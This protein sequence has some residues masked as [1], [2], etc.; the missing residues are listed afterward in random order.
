[1]R[2]VV[3]KFNGRQTTLLFR[4]PALGQRDVVPALSGR[5][6]VDV[7]GRL[8][9]EDDGLPTR[10]HNT[11]LPLRGTGWR[12]LKAQLNIAGTH[13]LQLDLERFRCRKN[14]RLVRVLDRRY[15]GKDTLFHRDRELL[16]HSKRRDGQES[17]YQ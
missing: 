12:L 11:L 17:D 15:A 10:I 16:A 8:L 1:M 6:I 14:Q 13:H 4:P 7:L 5:A 2:G 9:P 3:K